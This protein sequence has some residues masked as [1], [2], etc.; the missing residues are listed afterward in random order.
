M[1]SRA[2]E[3]QPFKCNY[4]CRYAVMIFSADKPKPSCQIGRKHYECWNISQNHWHQESKL[5]LEELLTTVAKKS[6]INGGVIDA[7]HREIKQFSK[8]VALD[9]RKISQMWQSCS[10][11]KGE[12]GQ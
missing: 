3:V 9:Y 6:A 11:R 8:V 5:D 12:S 2:C 1:N 10:C 7:D 4:Y